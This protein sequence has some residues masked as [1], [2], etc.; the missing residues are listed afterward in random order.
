MTFLIA[1][2]STQLLGSHHNNRFSLTSRVVPAVFLV[3]P[4]ITLRH[5]VHLFRRFVSSQHCSLTIHPSTNSPSISSFHTPLVSSIN[6]VSASRFLSQFRAHKGDH[7]SGSTTSLN[8]TSTH[9]TRHPIRSLPIPTRYSKKLIF[10]R[11]LTS[12]LFHFKRPLT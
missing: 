2:L 3:D 1:L 4:T 5:T 9:H 11:D 8:F 6:L 7:S 10:P 12:N